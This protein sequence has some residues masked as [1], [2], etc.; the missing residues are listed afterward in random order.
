MEVEGRR[1]HPRVVRVA[2]VVDV[3]AVDDGA[4]GKELVGQLLEEG[5][6]LVVDGYQSKDR[7]ARA[8]GRDVTFADGRANFMGS[9]GTGAPQD[10]R[11]ATE[12]N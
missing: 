9:S 12:R 4:L 6:L 3:A 8:N 5:A 2:R 11:D 7:T 10:G 1:L